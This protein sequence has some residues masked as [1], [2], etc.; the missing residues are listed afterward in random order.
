MQATGFAQRTAAASDRQRTGLTQRA[1]QTQARKFRDVDTTEL[2]ARMGAEL[3]RDYPGL[4]QALATVGGGQ[5]P[6][7]K[8]RFVT[9]TGTACT[10]TDCVEVAVVKDFVLVTDSKNPDGAPLVYTKREWQMFL[11]GVRAGEF[12]LESL[13]A[14]QAEYQQN[15][16][17]GLAMA[18]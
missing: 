10:M 18:V 14:E 3:G 5:L 7:A 2:L 17:S 8:L 11:D 4:L 1:G 9:A 13:E 15:P 12:D 6:D 16:E